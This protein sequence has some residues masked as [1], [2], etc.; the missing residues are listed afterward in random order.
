MA[1]KEAELQ[2]LAARLATFERSCMGSGF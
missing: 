1:A 2:A